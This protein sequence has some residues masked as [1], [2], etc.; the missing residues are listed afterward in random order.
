MKKLTKK[1][2]LLI[3]MTLFSMFFGAGNLI[4]PPLLGAHSGTNFIPAVFGFILTAVLLPTL[5]I[6]VV[7]KHHGLKNLTDRIHPL[8]SLVFITLVYLLIGPGVAIPRTA[9]TSYEMAIAPL[10]SSKMTS[11]QIVYALLFFAASTYIAL[12]P[13]RLKDLLGKYMTPLLLGLIL[14]VF[15][16]T[17][18]SQ[19]ATIGNAT[20]TYQHT[21]TVQGFIDGYQ[22]MDILA[23]L[24]FGIVIT[25]NVRD[26]GIYDDRAIARSIMKAGLI[27]GSLLAIIYLATGYIGAHT[28]M[29]TSTMN[30]GANI[31]T[32]AI[33]LAFGKAGQILV[34]LIFFIACF[35][36]CTG[37][38]SCVSEYFYTLIPKIPYKVWLIGFASL[39]FVISSMGLDFILD[40][41]TPVLEIICP[42]AVIVILFGLIISPKNE[43]TSD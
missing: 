28:S 35:N 33:D 18:V 36:V 20:Q 37:L 3:G 22:T 27:A 34:G 11:L 42:I 24:N 43:K 8:F 12:H 32:Y 25:L 13:N 26:F 9:S 7:A 39:S 10:L 19:D 38:L 14:L 1:Q 15:I 2:T 41:S 6:V 21:P 16:G 30:N 4:F 31:L 5:A 40:L 17:L 23:A 29:Y